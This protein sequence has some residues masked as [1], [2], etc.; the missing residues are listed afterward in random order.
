MADEY[1]GPGF[2]GR[3]VL[4]T[5][6]GGGIGR[7]AAL[8]FAAA[9][10]DVVAGDI[11][12]A[13]I[14]E[15]AA[16]AAERGRGTVTAQCCDVTKAD[17]VQ[18]LVDT[19]LSRS[20]RLD[21]AF[22]NAG[23]STAGPLIGDT[24]IEEVERALAVN[25]V[26]VWKCMI[27]ELAPM[28]EAGHGVIINTASATALRG[29]PRLAAYASTKAAVVQVS[30]SAALEYGEHGIRVH[31]LCPGPIDTPMLEDMP[32]A[33]RAQLAAAVPLRRLGT[34][35]EVAQ[36]VLWLCAPGAAYVNGMPV[37]VDGGETA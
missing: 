37:Y 29:T 30:R 14:K 5:G 19:A 15:T 27:A 34:S 33:R 31:P 1:E 23:V 24:R 3:T 25:V 22:N 12:D 6:A 8:A 21:F 17:D 32:A 16:L 20:G 26:G 28:V 10:A 9:G 36:V 2:A 7:A 4:I 18:Q 13:L 35:D 11:K